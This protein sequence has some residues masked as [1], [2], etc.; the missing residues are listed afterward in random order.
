[1]GEDGRIAWVL[2][3]LGQ[4]K[5]SVLDGGYPAWKASGEE[6]QKGVLE[7]PPESFEASVRPELLAT[8]EDV[9]DMAGRVGEWQAVLLDSRGADEF[10]GSPEAP[11]HGAA[12]RGHIPS[13]VNVEWKQLVDGQG[14]VRGLGELESLLIPAG[15]RPD[16]DIITYCTGG[17]RS[18]H[19]WYVLYSLGYPSVK[20]YSGSWWEWS[21]DRRLPIEIGGK[22]SRPEAPPWPPVDEPTPEEAASEEEQPPP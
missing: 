14:L 9:V 19:T 18:A 22:R 15:V 21:L 17:V 7:K 6:V 10:R 8:K 20:N 16:A 5:L 1:L 13:A 2:L 12:R 11:S 4:E 3:W